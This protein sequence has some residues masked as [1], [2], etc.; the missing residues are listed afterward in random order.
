MLR[1]TNYRGRDVVFPLGPAI[2]AAGLLVTAV[3]GS[4]RLADW[5]VY[6]VAV[7]LLGLVDDLRAAPVPAACAVMRPP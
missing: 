2:L 1:R 5:L 7:S 3:A 6:L 4:D